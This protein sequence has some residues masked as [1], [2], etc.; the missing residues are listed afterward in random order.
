[1]SGLE[2]RLEPLHKGGLDM[3]IYKNVYEYLVVYDSRKIL[4]KWVQVC[5]YYFCWWSIS[6][7]SNISRNEPSAGNQKWTHVTAALLS[8]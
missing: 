5:V 1:M 3:P 8:V 2:K 7:L 4:F 6:A